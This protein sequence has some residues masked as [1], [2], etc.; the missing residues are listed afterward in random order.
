MNK[1]SKLFKGVNLLTVI[2]TLVGIFSLYIAFSN[3]GPPLVI[4][5]TDRFSCELISHPNEGE[6]WTVVYRNGEKQDPWLKIAATLGS[7]WTPAE[8]CQEIA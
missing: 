8:R 7:N 4:Q 3:K 2:S 5:E 6:V 1:I